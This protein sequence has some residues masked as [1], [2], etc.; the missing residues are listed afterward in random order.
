MYP[1][2]VSDLTATFENT[3]LN[4]IKEYKD[5]GIRF[6]HENSTWHLITNLNLARNKDYSNDYA[7]N[8]LE[9]N[10]DAS[11]LVQFTT[12]GETYTIKSRQLDMYFASKEETRFYF[13][14]SVKIYD[15]VSGNTVKYCT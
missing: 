3:M 5:F 10:L 9:T 8:S 4:E 2:W 7:G 1:K 12:N 11:W 14:D 13:D 6:D 15:S